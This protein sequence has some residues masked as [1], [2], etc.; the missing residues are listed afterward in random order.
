MIVL[1]TCLTTTST[2]TQI[3]VVTQPV[4]LRAD[5]AT[6]HPPLRLPYPPQ[7][8][9]LIPPKESGDSYYVRTHQGEAWW[10]WT[11]NVSVDHRDECMPHG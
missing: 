10:A 5:P 7:H 1:G 6:E 8:W 11:H 2:Q 9:Q 4:H 3:A